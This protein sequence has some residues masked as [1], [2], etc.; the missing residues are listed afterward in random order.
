M[1]NGSFYRIIRGSVLV[2]IWYFK[3]KDLCVLRQ[4]WDEGIGVLGCEIGVLKVRQG[5]RQINMEKLVSLG[6]K[7]LSFWE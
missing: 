5:E 1:L 3:S 6:V 7:Y 2:G 4:D